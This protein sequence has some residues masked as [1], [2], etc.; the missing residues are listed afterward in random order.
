MSYSKEIDWGDGSVDKLYFSAPSS[1]GNQMVTVSSDANAGSERTKTVTFNA[2]GVSP[3]PLTIVQLPGGATDFDAWVKD[4]DT[5]LWIDIVND[6]QLTETVRIR[7]IGTIDWGDGSAK[8]SVSVTTATSF[9]HTYSEQGKYRIDLH[10]TSGT[11]LLGSASSSYCVMGARSSK[12]YCQLATL[13]QAE[14]GTSIITTLSN[15]AFYYCSG[16][17]K[18]YIPK[19]IVTVGT[20]MFYCCFCLATVIFEDSRTI[21][22]T[23]ASNI[24]YT[25]YNLQDVSTF[26]F[27][28]ITT[29][30]GTFRNCYS[31]ISA[32]IPPS[33]TTFGSTQVFQNCY[34]LKFMYCL[35]TT[36]PTLSA[37]HFAS[38][39]SDCVIKVP[40]GSLS[41][42]QSA[43]YWSA[44][45]SQMVEAAAVVM[46]L[47]NVYS[48]N[49]IPIADVNGSYTTTL[50]PHEGKTLGTVTVKMGGVDIS[51]SAYSGGVVTIASVTGNI[52]ITATA[53]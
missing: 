17:R 47:T 16:L 5:H 12:T 46:T 35:P 23:A 51:S 6:E 20:N 27:P 36:A 19:T 48:S 38:M 3:R 49:M 24:F 4:G 18:V 8:E 41:S 28:A 30:N 45:A 25:C 9:T 15:Y 7:M 22:S 14:I 26:Y 42:Y 31:L 40:I 39:N 11:F 53:S 32:V 43:S 1:E 2:S 50:T 44:R 37:D 13:Y 34:S 33:V 10:P 29:F 52:T 21:T